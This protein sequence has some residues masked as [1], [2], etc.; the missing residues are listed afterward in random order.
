[1]IVVIDVSGAVQILLKTEKALQ[2]KEA[3]DNAATVIAPDLFVPELTN[4]LWKYQRAKIF[5]EDECLLY[6]ERGIKLIDNF[7]DSKDYWKE[8]FAEGVRNK[9]PVYDMFYAVVAR[10][11]EGVLITND[12]DLAKI[13]QQLSIGYIF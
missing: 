3:V 13:C 4:T 8:A 10:R 6:I 12:G 1:M 5:S 9:H 7:V 11:N 2:F